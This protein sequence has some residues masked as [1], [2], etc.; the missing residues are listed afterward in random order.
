MPYPVLLSGWL[1]SVIGGGVA[2]PIIH[3]SILEMKVMSIQ[4]NKLYRLPWTKNDN[5]GG[6]VEVTDICNLSCPGCYR[7]TICGHRSLKEI[8]KEIIILKELINCDRI[9]ISGGEPLL[10]P[11]ILE[12]VDFISRQKIKPVMLTNGEDL[13]EELAKD[14]NKA[15]LAKFHFHVD[16][17][18]NRPG[19]I[20]RNETELNDLRQHFADIVWKLDGVQCGFNITVFKSS[21]KHLPGIIKWARLNIHKVQHISL[22]AF[23]AIPLVDNY[24]YRVKNQ[25]VDTS[26]LQHT[27]DNIDEINLTTNEMYEILKKY[28]PDYHVGAYLGGSTT[29]DTYKFLIAVQVGSPSSLFGFLGAKTLEY[30]QVFHHLFNKHYCSFISQSKIGRKLFLMSFTDKEVRKAFRCYLKSIFHNLTRLF[31]GVYIQ[32]ISLQQPNEILDGKVNLCDGCLNMM[33]H[34]GTLIPSCRW[35][36]Y[37]LYGGPIVPVIRS[38]N[39]IEK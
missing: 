2:F 17:G 5:P 26:K 34:E 31:D 13:T 1:H 4:R 11:D 23:R 36:E 9:A 15:G 10:Y 19:W 29:P 25:T 30:T 32:S 7:H 3:F 8:K 35:D 6:W 22:I 24:E 16:S 39:E 18:M 14:L 37:R 21:A 38:S 27:I 12:V 28:D 33:I 20:N